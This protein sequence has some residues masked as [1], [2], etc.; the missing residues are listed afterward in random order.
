VILYRNVPELSLRSEGDGRTVFGFAVRYGQADPISDAQGS[1]S[2]SWKQGVFAR[3]LGE[4]SRKIKLLGNHEQRKMPLGVV[5]AARDE[6]AGLYVEAHVSDTA[7][8]NEALQLIADG[9]VDGFSVGFTPVRDQWSRDRRSVTRIEAALRE[10]S[11]TA[12]PAISGALVAGVRT[13]SRSLSGEAAARRYRLLERTFSNG[14][15]PD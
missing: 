6:P 7:A 15:Q 2:E 13:K 1:Y 3:S 9:A 5:T 11:L 12:F 10:L 8:G 4:R 14:Y